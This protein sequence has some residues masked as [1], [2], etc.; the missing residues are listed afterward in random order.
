MDLKIKVITNYLI[1]FYFY[2]PNWE[3]VACPTNYSPIRKIKYLT[4]VLL[5]DYYFK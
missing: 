1:G 3:V 5:F 4:K 2:P